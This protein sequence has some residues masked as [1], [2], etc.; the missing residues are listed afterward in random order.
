MAQFRDV[1]DSKSEFSDA[2]L[3]GGSD[4]SGAGIGFDAQAV[5][6]FKARFSRP[7]T[8]GMIEFA[9]GEK[10]PSR[11]ESDRDRER[12]RMA[13]MYEKFVPDS[14][15]T[16][17]KHA[18]LPSLHSYRGKPEYGDARFLRSLTD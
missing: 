18:M 5:A 16:L 10:E 1:K 9:V 6:Q 7:V 2:L 14:V 13:K 3:L 11:G 4:A 8:S 17:Q 15:R 12:E